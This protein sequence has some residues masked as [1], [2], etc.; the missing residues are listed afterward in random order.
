MR[1][2]KNT[3]AAAIFSVLVSGS[4]FAAGNT[5]VVTDVGNA[6]SGR[7]VSLDLQSA[8]DVSAF[9]FALDL[10]AGA[11]NVNTSKCLSDLPKGYSGVCESKDSRVAAVIFSSNNSPLPAGMVSLGTI[12]FQ[13][14]QAKSGIQVSELLGA[15][16][17]GA[18]TSVTSEVATD[19]SAGGTQQQ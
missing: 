6:K 11:K 12:S 14:G 9:Q 7:V 15:S 5:V 16:P 19:N 4:A 10:P 18:A 3:M 8:G 2:L 1:N 17:T 13:G